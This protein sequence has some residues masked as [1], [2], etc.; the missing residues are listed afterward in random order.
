MPVRFPNEAQAYGY[1]KAHTDTCKRPEFIDGTWLVPNGKDEVTDCEPLK[2]R[3]SFR[4]RGPGIR[5]PK[6]PTQ[7]E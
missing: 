3:K 7:E 1:W 4:P 6:V 2:E 5:G